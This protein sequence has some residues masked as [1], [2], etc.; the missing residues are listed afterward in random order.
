MQLNLGGKRVL[1]T[2]ASAG[3][4]E[5][6]AMALADEGAQ[7]TINSRNRERLAA[8]AERIKDSTGKEPKQVVGDVTVAEDI[9]RMATEVGGIDILVSNA[10]GPPHGKFSDHSDAKW[11]AAAELVLFSAIRL[12][13]AFIEGMAERK[14]GRLIYITSVGVRQP[15]DDL[16][17]SNTFRTGVTG[18][19]KTISNNYARLGI[20]ANCVCPGYTATERLNELVE[21]RAETDGVS[22]DRIREEFASAIPVGRLGKPSESASLIA[23]LASERAAYIT[24]S[25][26]AVDGGLVK[27]LL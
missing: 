24:G 27:S 20:T 18:F 11:M 25:S 13:R 9:T 3:L 7:V 15:I 23:F 10:G 14:F 2:G 17:L 16:I 6:A 8:S 19:C 12:T 21:A 22:T 1:V 4:G 26:I 5:A